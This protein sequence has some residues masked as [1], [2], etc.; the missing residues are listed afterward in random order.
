[1][2]SWRAREGMFR[3]T[4]RR[5]SPAQ[6]RRRVRP[7]IPRAFLLTHQNALHPG[8]APGRLQGGGAREWPADAG[9][10]GAAVRA[11]NGPSG[12][13]C[14]AA[15]RGAPPA[16]RSGAGHAGA[17]FVRRARGRAPRL[18]RAAACPQLMVRQ[19]PLTPPHP[20]RASARP[21]PQVRHMGPLGRYFVERP[22][23][24]EE[25]RVRARARPRRTGGRD[26][27]RPPPP[28]YIDT[29]LLRRLSPLPPPLPPP[30]PAMPCRSCSRRR[31]APRTPRRSPTRWC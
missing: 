10:P 25:A 7:Q 31:R 30:A 27:A 4:P 21:R 14:G 1:M 9:R 24:V 19:Q 20:F 17:A 18:P 28:V 15:P 23:N 6:T 13:L 8:A 11:A 16:P 12:A 5:R 26:V 22:N 2:G 3:A 29:G